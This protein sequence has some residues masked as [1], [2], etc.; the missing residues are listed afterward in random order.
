MEYITPEEVADQLK[1]SAYTVKRWLRSGELR[2]VRLGKGGHWRTTDEWLQEFLE[3]S[4]ESA[5]KTAA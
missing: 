3:R 5:S 1:V 2:G 4:T